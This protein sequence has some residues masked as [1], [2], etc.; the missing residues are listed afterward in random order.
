[1]PTGVYPRTEE[2]RRIN[3]EGHSRYWETHTM[4]VKT[5]RK[6]SIALTKYYEKKKELKNES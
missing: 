2:H 4:A 3:S 5:R 1:M 6:I